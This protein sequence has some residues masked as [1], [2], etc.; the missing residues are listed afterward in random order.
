MT[1]RED[2]S[3]PSLASAP[4]P[5]LDTNVDSNHSSVN[6]ET[7]APMDETSDN[8]PI[9]PPSEADSNSSNAATKE[10]NSEQENA[11]KEATEKT[12]STNTSNKPVPV[13]KPKASRDKNGGSMACGRVTSKSHVTG[14]ES[15]GAG[16]G[17]SRKVAL[18]SQAGMAGNYILE[19][20]PKV[21]GAFRSTETFEN[22]EIAANGE[23][24]PENPKTV[25]F[26]KCEPFKPGAKPPAKLSG[27]KTFGKKISKIWVYFARL[28]SFFGNFGKCCSIRF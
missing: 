23:K 5:D 1:T 20:D 15:G 25:E 7:V 21:N 8:E 12:S 28:S 11:S 2:N 14:S 17:T 13:S 4:E 26:P 6:D 24:F 10:T 27:K 16:S 3:P 22:L 9:V 19:P 18:N